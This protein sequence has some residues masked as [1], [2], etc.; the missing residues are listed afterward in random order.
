MQTI[1]LNHN[2]HQ[3]MRK[4]KFKNDNFQKKAETCIQE[5]LGLVDY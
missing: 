5:D 3:D 2:R 1:Q 4:L